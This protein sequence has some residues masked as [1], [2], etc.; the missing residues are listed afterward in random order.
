MNEEGSLFNSNDLHGFT[1]QSG[2]TCADAKSSHRLVVM[3]SDQL[4]HTTL[5]SIGEV[6]VLLR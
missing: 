3:K 6:V 5:P 1:I 2:A 4:Y